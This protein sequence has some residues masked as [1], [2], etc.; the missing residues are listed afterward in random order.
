M[1]QSMMFR[2]G[3]DQTEAMANMR[4]E[5]FAAYEQA[6]RSWLARVRSEVDLWCEADKR[7]GPMKN[8]IGSNPS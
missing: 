3:K 7:Y 4:R 5:V 8:K 6:S 2:L 1:P